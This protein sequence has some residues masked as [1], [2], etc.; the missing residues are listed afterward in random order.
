[1]D[2]RELAPALLALGDLVESASLALYGDKV[3]AKIEVKASFKTGSFGID[4]ILSQDFRQQVLLFLTSQ[5]VTGV[6]NAGE[7]I[8]MLFGS[9][10]VGKN[11]LIGV[12]KW[13]KNRKIKT[14]QIK[15][16]K[17]TIITQDDETLDVEM[18]VIQLLRDRA[19]RQNLAKTLAPL[20]Q[21]GISSVAFG[22]DV[23]K[24]Y[25]VIEKDEKDFFVLPP[26]EDTLIV[27]EHRQMIFSI[28]SLAFKEDNKWRLHDGNATI[29]ALITDIDFLGRVDQN[30]ETF[31]KGDVLVCL[32]HI[33][34]WQT[35]EGAKTEYTIEKIIE[36]RQAARQIA[37]PYSS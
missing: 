28:V 35:T 3:Q 36:H 21:E 12:L 26:D 32:V 17:A 31:S 30:L 33:Q 8:A 1:M 34:Q 16:N 20:Q 15:E 29:H 10:I 23:E 18:R 14:V 37:L 4:F 7:L 27:D 9:V 22:E 6:I 5:E 13:L 2:V 19:V 25:D 24:I 11:G